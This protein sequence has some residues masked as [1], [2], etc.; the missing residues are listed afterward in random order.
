MFGLLGVPQQ[1]SPLRRVFEGLICTLCFG[2]TFQCDRF[3]EPA[4]SQGAGLRRQKSRKCGRK[5]MV[6]AETL[7]EG[8]WLLR[9]HSNPEHSQHNH[10]RSI[11]HL[12]IPP[13]RDSP[14]LSGQRSNRQA[15]GSEFGPV[16]SRINRDKLDGHTPTAALIKLLDEMKIP[17]LVKWGGDEPN[18]LV[19]LVWAFPYCLQMWKRFPEVISFDN[20]YN[21]NRF[22]LP[23]FQAT[24]QTCLG[25]VYNAAFGLIDNERREGF[26]FLSG[27]IRQL[28]EQHSIR[29]PDVIVTD[30][31]DQMKAALN[32]QF[33]DVQQ[34]LCI[35]HIN[36]NVLLKSKQ[37]WVRAR[38]TSRNSSP[39]TSDREATTPQPQARL[40]PQGREFVH[41]P[42][43]E[44]ISHNYRGVLT[45]WK[46]V[47]FAET[48]EAHEEAW[49]NLCK[50]FD[51]QRAILRYLN[52]TYMSVRAQWARCLIRKY[53]NFGVRVT[54]GT[55][56]SNNIKSYLL[57]GMSNLYRLF[58]A[59]QDM[60]KDQERDFN[61]A[62]EA[63]EVLTAREYIGSSSGYL[64]ELRTALSS[65]G[66]GLITKQYWLAKK[67]MR[68]EK[69][70][71]PDPLGDCG[72]ECSVSTEFGIPC[73]HRI[74]SKLVNGMPFTRWE[75]HPRWRLREP[76]SQDAYRR[77]LDPRIATALRGKPKNTT[78][79]IP[80]RL[81]IEASCQTNSRPTR[82]PASQASGR[83]RGRPLGRLNKPTLARLPLESSQQVSS[84][85]TSQASTS[86]QRQTRRRS[87][88][89]GGG[90][91]TGV[92]ASGRKTQP[93]I[94][95]RR[96]QW[97]LLD[98]DEEVLPSAGLP[99]DQINNQ[100]YQSIQSIQIK[101]G[102][103]TDQSIQTQASVHLIYLCRTERA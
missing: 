17:Y 10:S 77:I 20:T 100:I 40:S 1:R 75:V 69:N 26:Q 30:F 87:A 99:S 58:E 19:G 29:Q 25:S 88:V 37:K 85:I 39:D 18:R 5:W 68:T 79:A 4:P 50:E 7:E 22:K 23:L 51:D 95:R 27:S 91:T 80:A 32:D 2:Y 15:A 41:M 53:R 101:Y 55:E 12:L 70:P 67:A 61:D 13:I 59:M 35:H 103:L 78:Q 45:M 64:G 96:S 57:N 92:R 82:K 36:S 21:T 74:Y 89:L 83:R 34:Q 60:M 14:S 65:K 33:P 86:S 44:A 94:R 102:I 11:G 56:A 48:E 54:S 76:S 84:Q 52:G 63:D 93:S 8:K 42:I 6:I 31:D 73:C 47:L 97:E 98:S 49:A 16:T 72:E 3:G 9:Q 46:L 38:S 81:A 43:T 71:F 62:C 28:A 66:L 90:R 24:G